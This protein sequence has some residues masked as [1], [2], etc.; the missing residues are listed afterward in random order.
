MAAA[1]LVLVSGLRC[2]E[3]CDGDRGEPPPPGAD[4]RDYDGAWQWDVLAYA[5]PALLA[6][7]IVYLVAVVWSLKRTAVGACA[8]A[9]VLTTGAATWE[10]GGLGWLDQLGDPDVG[11]WIVGGFGVL[12]AG[13]VLMPAARPTRR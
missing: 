11:L 4:W 7:M 5:A 10:A 12:A 9:V 3:G 8:A 1:I 13:V 6:V 2:D